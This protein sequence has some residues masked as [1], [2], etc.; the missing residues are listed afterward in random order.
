MKHSKSCKTCMPTNLLE[1]KKG[2]GCK[3]IYSGL[4]IENNDMIN[5]LVET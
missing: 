5:K 3:A 1:F 2:F 4:K